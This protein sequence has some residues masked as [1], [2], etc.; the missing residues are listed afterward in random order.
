M[1]EQCTSRSKCSS[2][3]TTSHIV[4]T[5][6]N[7]QRKE[8]V[9][10]GNV[11]TATNGQTEVIAVTHFQS[12]HS[13]R[14]KRGSKE[15]LAGWFDALD[16]CYKRIKD[17]KDPVNSVRD[18]AK[19]SE[20][21][22]SFATINQYMSHC[23]WS[24]EQGYFRTWDSISDIRAKRYEKPANSKGDAKVTVKQYDSV[25]SQAKSMSKA[26]RKRLA[27]ALLAMD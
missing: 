3:T 11:R 21:E 20:G 23:L 15:E 8:I 4:F 5:N 27:M 1:N 22:Y 16:E 26:D 10:A 18:Y 25:L 17:K 7:T 19:A 24:D 2:F 12:V 14:I 6:V 9:I 13:K